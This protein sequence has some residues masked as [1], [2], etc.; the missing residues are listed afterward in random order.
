MPDQAWVISSVLLVAALFLAW[1]LGPIIAND[2][3]VARDE[4]SLLNKRAAVE[5]IMKSGG[6]RTLSEYLTV[7]PEACSK[8]GYRDFL[9]WYESFGG[10]HIWGH[11]DIR[12]WDHFLECQRCGNTVKTCNIGYPE[13][14][15]QLHRTSFRA[16]SPYLSAADADQVA[17]FSPTSITV[18]H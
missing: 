10:A 15:L 6:P 11:E 3:E 2:S 1:I 4:Q 17:E 13:T 9:S 8:C 7:F 16:M 5:R 18:G 14:A 12:E